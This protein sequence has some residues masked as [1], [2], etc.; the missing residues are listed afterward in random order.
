MADRTFVL[1]GVGYLQ[2][3]RLRDSGGRID[4]PMFAPTED[5]AEQ[6]ARENGAGMA[7]ERWTITA[8]NAERAVCSMA[9]VL[10]GGSEP[11]VK[12]E[13]LRSSGVGGEAW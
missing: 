4:D 5:E 3:G 12:I 9:F 8:E 6:V 10:R 13:L 2:R 7:M 1:F 11:S